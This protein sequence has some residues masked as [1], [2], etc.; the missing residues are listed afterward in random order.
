MRLASGF[1]VQI[2]TRA[3]TR[4]IGASNPPTKGKVQDMHQRQ[5]NRVCNPFSSN[6]GYNKR[7]SRSHN[8]FL[9]LHSP[10]LGEAGSNA[11]HV[12][13]RSAAQCATNGAV[14]CRSGEWKPW[15][16]SVLALGLLNDSR[17]GSRSATAVQFYKKVSGSDGVQSSMRGKCWHKVLVDQSRP[18]RC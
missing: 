3:V 9:F 6:Q 5:H 13:Q 8:S 14:V 4:L 1:P 17:E 15:R 11:V 10:S 2:S 7:S 12:A 18:A 16:C